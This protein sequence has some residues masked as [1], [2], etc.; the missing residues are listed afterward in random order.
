[1]KSIGKIF[2]TGLLTVLPLLATV[3]FTLWVLGVVEDFFGSVLLW[4]IPERYY[5][6]GMGLMIAIGV[7]FAI[8]LLMRA[9]LFRRLFAWAEAL[10]MEV[11]LVR[12]VYTA[13]R[14]MFGLFAQRDGKAALQVVSVTLPGSQMRLIGFVTRTDFSDLPAGIAREGEVA[15]YLPMGYM[16]GGYT[17][18]LPREQVQPIDMSREDAMKFVLTAGLKSR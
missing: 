6:T 9:L 18:F 13:L 12:S 15:V 1:M 2:A 4:L 5:S 14:D 7:V 8:G 10:L 11:P 17:V 3:Y 16:I